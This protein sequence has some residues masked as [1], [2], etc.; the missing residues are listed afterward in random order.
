MS[1]V[2]QARAARCTQDNIEQMKNFDPELARKAQIAY[3]NKA[4]DVEGCQG[5]VESCGGAQVLFLGGK[6]LKKNITYKV[7]PRPN[8]AV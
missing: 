4:Q 7:D 2:H 1:M 6:C 8:T 3:D 5:L